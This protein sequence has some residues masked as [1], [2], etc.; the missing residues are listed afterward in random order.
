MKLTPRALRIIIF[1]CFSSLLVIL[2]QVTKH[3]VVQNFFYGESVL[4]IPSFFSLTYVRNPGAAFG[5]LSQW[6]SALRIPFFII[7]PF[8]AL[9][10]ILSV[11]RRLPENDWRLG[12][13]LS[14]VMGGAFGNLIDRARLGYVIDFLDFHWGMTG[15]HFPAFNVADIAICVGVGLLMID[16]YCREKSAPAANS[17]KNS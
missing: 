2:D 7:I 16:M 1:L 11:F 9:G 17:Q 14:L 3:L 6:D 13:A 8:V 4:M 10:V 15:L 5:L 12:F